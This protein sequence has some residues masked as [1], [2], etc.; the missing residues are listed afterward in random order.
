[1]V[2][3]TVGS[4]MR[5]VLTIVKLGAIV[6]VLAYASFITTEW[7]GC[8]SYLQ[9]EYELTFIDADGNPIEG[10]ELQVE[11][12]SGNEFFCFPVTDYWPNRIPRT[13]EHGVMRFHHVRAGA[14]W[15]NYGWSLFWLFPIPT[16]RSPVYICRFLHGE[17]EVHRVPF[18]ELDDWDWP[19]QTWEQ[20]PKVKRQ[21]NWSAMIPNEIY[22]ADEANKIDH[23]RL[24][25]FFHLDGKDRPTRES[26][27]AC[28]Y[29]ERL[30]SKI[31]RATASKQEAV[32]D[33]EFPVIRRTIVIELPGDG[34]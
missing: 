28:R 22:R 32:E 23:S 2:G 31:D 30:L 17:K 16:T 15:D 7:G 5:K 25:S 11:D 3:G 34:R 12:Q 27:V 10:I 9:L 6:A 8:C 4:A 18:G 24:M 1:L 33:V 13:D 20:V 21:F 19:G 14:E 29:G 26:I